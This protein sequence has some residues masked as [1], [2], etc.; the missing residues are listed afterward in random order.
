MV[1]WIFPFGRFGKMNSPLRELIVFFSP[2]RTSTSL[3]GI[4]VSDSK[5]WPR[6]TACCALRCQDKNIKTTVVRIL[7][8]LLCLYS[9]KNIVNASMLQIKCINVAFVFRKK[10]FFSYLLSEK[11]KCGGVLFKY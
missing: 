2:T 1:S 9:C 3:K 10:I 6:S 4:A 8:I 11:D 7:N 5:I